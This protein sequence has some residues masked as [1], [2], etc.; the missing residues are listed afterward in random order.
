[1]WT[2]Q[3]SRLAWGYT[4][5]TQICLEITKQRSINTDPSSFREY[6]LKMLPAFEDFG[7]K[8]RY[9]RNP[10]DAPTSQMSPRQPIKYAISFCRKPQTTLNQSDILEKS[11]SK[12]I[13]QVR[14]TITQW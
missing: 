11:G 5:K 7:S 10:I 3:C 8:G 6:R 14:R 1:M 4:K 13:C 12:R 2:L 9:V